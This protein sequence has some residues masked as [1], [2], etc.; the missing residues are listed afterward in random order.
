[1]TIE[2][3]FNADFAKKEI[4]EAATPATHQDKSQLL[5]IT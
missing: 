5:S 2:G 3:W 1:M 4:V